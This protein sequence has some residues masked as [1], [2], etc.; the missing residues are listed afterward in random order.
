MPRFAAFAVA[1]IVSSL[2]NPALAPGQARLTGADLVGIVSDQSGAAVPGATVT[3]TNSG[4]NLVRT[5]V[6]D[7]RGRYT[8]AALPPGTYEIS[9]TLSGCSAAHYETD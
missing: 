9:T 8:V 5:A 4:T 2:L 1:A 7:E 3:V 6:T